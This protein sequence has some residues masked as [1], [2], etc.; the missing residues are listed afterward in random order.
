M[1]KRRRSVIE[2]KVYDDTH[3]LPRSRGDG[4]LRREVWIDSAGRVSRYNLAYINHRLCQVDNGRVIGYDNGHGYHHRHFFG[5]VEAVHFVSYEDIEDRFE[6]D[7]R[8]LHEQA[9]H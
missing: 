1:G 9:K 7:W 3:H 2:K 5:K 8:V 6:K 4:I